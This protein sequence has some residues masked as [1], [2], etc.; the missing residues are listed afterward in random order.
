MSKI[1]KYKGINLIYIALTILNCLLRYIDFGSVKYHCMVFYFQ[2]LSNK[3]LMEAVL[4]SD[5]Q[6]YK[7][8]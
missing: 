2:V 4:T 5:V 6:A 1:T 7:Y 3:L 8:Y